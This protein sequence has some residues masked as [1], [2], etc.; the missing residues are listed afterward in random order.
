VAVEPS[1]EDAYTDLLARATP[2]AGAAPRVPSVAL[3]A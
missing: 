3:E 2:I 1:L